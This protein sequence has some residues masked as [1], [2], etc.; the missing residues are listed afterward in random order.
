MSHALSF[1]GVV[2]PGAA[3][4]AQPISGDPPLTRTLVPGVAAGIVGFKLFPKHPL[5]GF[6]GAESIG[7][8]A[9]RLW[10]GQGDDRLR[11]FTNMAGAASAITGSLLYKKHPFIG[12][13]LGLVAG[14]FMTSFVRGSNS[15]KFKQELMRRMGL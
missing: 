10:R 1:L 8:N 11:A 4:I 14:A 3:S 6:L 7:Q 2:S 5:L 12:F 9:Y 13:T 15:Q